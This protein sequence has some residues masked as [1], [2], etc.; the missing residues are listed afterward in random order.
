MRTN[1]LSALSAWFLLI[2]GLLGSAVLGLWQEREIRRDYA[3][4]FAR[5]TDQ[6]TLNIEERLKAYALVLR[7]GA[8]YF[9]GSDNVSREEW[10]NFVFQLRTYP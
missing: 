8:G 10:R 2:A 6:I 9:A 5:T 1:K 7:A 4:D 3:A